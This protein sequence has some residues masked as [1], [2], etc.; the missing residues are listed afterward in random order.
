MAPKD[1]DRHSL[2]INSPFIIPPDLKLVIF[3]DSHNIF[4]IFI[5]EKNQVELVEFIDL[6]EFTV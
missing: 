5:G 6:D 2:Q 3:V 1:G 4:L